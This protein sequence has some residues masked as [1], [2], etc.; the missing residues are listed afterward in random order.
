[1]VNENAFLAN[2]DWTNVLN[3]S[4][5]VDADWTNVLKVA[6]ADWTNVCSIDIKQRL[7]IQVYWLND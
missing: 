1:M 3:V 5:A 6:D 2:A 7:N 4:K